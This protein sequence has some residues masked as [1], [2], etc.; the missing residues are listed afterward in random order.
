MNEGK[1]S[2]SRIKLLKRKFLVFMWS[3]ELGKGFVYGSKNHPNSSCHI[4]LEEFCMT[5]SLFY[6]KWFRNS[7]GI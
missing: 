5:I 7:I 2:Y 1:E 4:L 6:S 3:S